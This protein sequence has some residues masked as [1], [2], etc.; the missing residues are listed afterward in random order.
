MKPMWKGDMADMKSALI[1]CYAEAQELGLLKGKHTAADTV[2]FVLM[3]GRSS[4][5]DRQR[6]LFD[7]G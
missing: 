4:C 3:S 2:K 5:R 6:P 1:A 7:R